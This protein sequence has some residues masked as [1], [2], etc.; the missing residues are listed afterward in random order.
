MPRMR[1]KCSW[2]MAFL[3][4]QDLKQTPLS[5]LINLIMINDDNIFRQKFL[6]R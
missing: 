4:K 6:L 3:T 1:H 2:N 5:P